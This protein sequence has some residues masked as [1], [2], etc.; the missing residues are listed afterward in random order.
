MFISTTAIELHE[1]NEEKHGQNGLELRLKFLGTH[2]NFHMLC[3][4][5]IKSQIDLKLKAKTKHPMNTKT[6][7]I[8]IYTVRYIHVHTCTHIACTHTHTTYTRRSL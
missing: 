1:F 3:S 7:A 6:I 4:A 5:A 2:F 8:P